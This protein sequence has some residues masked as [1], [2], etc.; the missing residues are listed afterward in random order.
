MASSGTLKIVQQIMLESFKDQVW[1]NL[2]SEYKGT[3]FPMGTPWRPVNNF[4]DAQEIAA[5][6]G[7]HTKLII[8]PPQTI[9]LERA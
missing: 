5:S 1:I 9:I 8:T 6:W 7:L 2:N 3:D 4:K